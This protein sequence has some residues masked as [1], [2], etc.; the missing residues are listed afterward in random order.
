MAAIDLTVLEI[1]K[2]APEICAGRRMPDFFFSEIHLTVS[3]P[4]IGDDVLDCI[5]LFLFLLMLFAS[6]F[7]A[8]KVSVD[9]IWIPFNNRIPTNLA[10]VDDHDHDRSLNELP[11]PR[12]FRFLS[13]CTKKVSLNSRA[14][15][16]YLRWE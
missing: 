15:H 7:C 11:V 13:L 8:P 12:L 10:S 14:H 1:E 16:G 4:P 6:F 9:S 3:V 5:V 2:N